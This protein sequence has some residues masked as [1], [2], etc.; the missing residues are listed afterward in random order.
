MINC[1]G[2][3]RKGKSFLTDIFVINL[4]KGIANLVLWE[5]WKGKKVTIFFLIQ[6][7]REE[8]VLLEVFV[9]FSFF[10]RYKKNSLKFSKTVPKQPP[11]E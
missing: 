6:P 10:A 5:I 4:Y 2:Y 7:S 11:K 3:L 9:S 1:Y 8:L